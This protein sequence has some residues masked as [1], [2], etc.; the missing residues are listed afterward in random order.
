MGFDAVVFD[1]GGTLFENPAQRRL[2]DEPT[3]TEVWQT[4]LSRVTGC[5]QGLRLPFDPWQVEEI[6]KELEESLPKQHGP[7]YSYDTL[8]GAMLRRLDY[9][10]KGAWTCLLADAYAGPRYASWLFDGVPEMLAAIEQMGIEMHL[11]VNTH[12]CGFSMKRALAGV[13]LLGYFRSR[14]YSSD[15]QLAKPDPRF[16]RLTE[17]RAHLEGKRAVYVGDRIE[18]DVQGPKAIGWAAALRLNDENRSQAHLADYT[19]EHSSELVAWLL[20][21]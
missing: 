19:F 21:E 20:E 4:R 16:F 17:R 9:P 2:H 18:E 11:A 8:M 12:W 1:S 13:G 6:L 15:A 14:T 3:C 5:L 10:A 7:L